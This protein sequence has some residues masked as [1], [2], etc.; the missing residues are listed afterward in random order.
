MSPRHKSAQ[1]DWILLDVVRC[2]DLRLFLLPNHTLFTRSSSRSA[3]IWIRS[4]ALS[5]QWG[6]KSLEGASVSFVSQL[7]VA[8]NLIQ[9]TLS[10]AC[11][12]QLKSD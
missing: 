9:S 3:G 1:N 11:Y 4:G 12:S 2:Y 8:G 10:S 5:L 6:E 7:K